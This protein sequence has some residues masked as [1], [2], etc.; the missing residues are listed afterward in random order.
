MGGLGRVEK[1]KAGPQT[2]SRKSNSDEKGSG[3]TGF[4][5]TGHTGGAW[6]GTRHLPGE[7][8]SPPRGSPGSVGAEL[9]NLGDL[10]KK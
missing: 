2:G 7:Q 9:C 8:V 1:K 6:A 3:A 4:G 10:F 5:D